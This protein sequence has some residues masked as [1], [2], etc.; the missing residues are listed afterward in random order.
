MIVVAKWTAADTADQHGRTVII[1][2]AS[3]RLTG[4]RAPVDALWRE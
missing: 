3:E 1:T 4:L 2:G